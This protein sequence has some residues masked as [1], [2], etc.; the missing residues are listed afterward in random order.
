MHLA[1]DGQSP[2]LIN[3]NIGTNT[4]YFFEAY[5]N[6][7]NCASSRVPATAAIVQ[8]PGA[9]Q[10]TSAFR[11][12]PGRVSITATMGVPA[13]TQLM[14]F[15]SAAGSSPI[16]I[17]QQSPFTVTTPE[18]ST[19]AV[20]Y[21]VSSNGEGCES[22][23]TAVFV[24][25][26]PIPAPPISQDVVRCAG[27][28]V[29]FSATMANPSGNLIQLYTVP[30]GGVPIVSDNIVPYELTSTSINSNTT[31]YLET[32]NTV[33]NCSSVTRTAVVA[34][35][36]TTN[37][38]V[39]AQNDG[40]KCAGQ[41]LKLQTNTI[42]PGVTY[43]WTGPGGF[44]ATGNQ[45][46]RQLNSSL[47][48]GTYSVVAVANGCTSRVSSTVVEVRNTL[49]TPQLS[50]ANSSGQSRP[51]CEGEQLTLQVTNANDF[52]PIATYF[53]TGPLL[54]QATDIPRTLVPNTIS[55]MEGQYYVSVVANGCTSAISSPVN[56]QIR[57]NP[58]A[59]V[60]SSTAGSCT[61][62]DNIQLNAA[63][64]SGGQTYQWTGPNGFSQAGQNISLPANDNSSGTYFVRVIDVFGCVS[65]FAS[66]TVTVAAQP[67]APNL[68]TNAPL[69]ENANLTITVPEQFNTLYYIT[70]PNGYTALGPGPIFTR[71][72][73]SPL[74]AGAYSVTAI[75]GSCSS[76]VRSTQVGIV[77]K[78]VTP[79]LTSNSPV[80]SGQSLDFTIANFQPGLTYRVSGPNNYNATVTSANFSRMGV[81]LSDAGSYTIYAIQSG[82]SSQ[83]GS[84]NATV[85][86]TPS[87][88]VIANNGPL[89]VGETLSLSVVF[90]PG[91]AM[92]SWLGPNSYTAMGASAT[93]N[94]TSTQ[95][96]GI[97][98]LIASIGS[99]R[100]LPATTRA[101]V[102]IRPEQ[103]TVT[104]DGPKCTGSLI[105]LTAS[106]SGSNIVYQWTGPGG[107]SASGSVVTRSL[108]S[109]NE[110]GVYSV[111]AIAGNCTSSIGVTNVNAS[112]AISMPTVFNNGPKC[113]G[114]TANFTATGSSGA[115]YTWFGP[116]GFLGIGPVITRSNLTLSDNGVY[117]VTASFNGC[118]SQTATTTLQVNNAPLQ[119]QIQANQAPCVGNVLQ[120]T[121]VGDRG[122]TYIW[123]GPNNF[124]ATGATVTR[125]LNS[126]FDAGNYSVV[127]IIAGCTSSTA[128]RPISVGS[129][130]NP[131]PPSIQHNG[132]VCVGDII[133]LTAA[134]GSPTATYRWTGPNGFVA[135]G[136]VVSR[137][138]GSVL[139]GGEYTLEVNDGPCNSGRAL[140]TVLVNTA[141][142]P[143]QVSGTRTVC[144]GE[145]INLAA[146]N[147]SG[148]NY[149]WTGPAGFSSTQQQVSIFNASVFNSGIYSVVARNGNC[150][151]QPGTITIQVAE[152]PV[153]NSVTSNSPLCAGQTLLL[154]APSISGASYF[155]SGPN[156]YSANLQ[157]PSRANIA[158]NQAGNYAV[159]AVIGRCTS[160]VAQVSVV[161]NNTPPP[162]S[163][164][165]NGTVCSGQNIQLFAA[166]INNAN[167]QWTGPAGFTSFLQN[168]VI[169]NAAPFMSGI[170]SLMAVVGNCSSGVSIVN[171]RVNELPTAS[172]T[173]NSASICL[174]NTAGYSIEFT[175]TGPWTLTMVE[176][177]QTL[178]PTLIGSAGSGNLFTYQNTIT[179]TTNTTI[180]LSNVVDGNGCR[181]TAS[182]TYT[183]AVSR[184]DGGSTCP[185][186]VEIRAEAITGTSA[187][188]RWN[189]VPVPATCYI[190]A[191]GPTSVDPNTWTQQ[192]V[193]HPSDRLPITGLIPGLTYGVSVRTNCSAC[194]PTSGL[195]STPSASFSFFS[196]R[197]RM[198]STGASL[199]QGEDGFDVELYPNPARD[200]VQLMISGLTMNN[201]EKIVPTI[202]LIDM[203]G[204]ILRHYSISESTTELSLEGLTSGFYFVK[205]KAHDN[206]RTI[207]LLKQ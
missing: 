171:V 48:G 179:P 128:V 102:S 109:A 200:A 79:T 151:S 117:S 140:S 13:G 59:P 81:G 35:I 159:F 98:S 43:V 45:V 8:R 103:P 166:P 96:G 135:N 199:H 68:Q 198:S 4:T 1:S 28:I 176:N 191:Y 21:L 53:W 188:L 183:V 165:S 27:G 73:V 67:Q 24:Q 63:T 145:T 31:F 76:S 26:N 206:V 194:S 125:S 160:R 83:L 99:C 16:S 177:G 180:S 17:G 64:V 114:E 36:L 108:Q 110:A 190:V 112:P 29:T 94:L 164:S 127:A 25:L 119:P 130:A 207:K 38:S 77:S 93:R 197:T 32:V 126:I 168:P 100:S 161:V 50:F 69:C 111:I 162:P 41:T 186:P 139:D 60:P 52:P 182:G 121:A 137:P 91:G 167:Y 22:N 146:S 97:Y 19:N 51:L 65:P 154:T 23:R 62:N 5:N 120:L 181:G 141:P 44:S 2:Y 104:N 55:L 129:T 101:V 113:V 142:A 169:N 163:I 86:T 150:S 12:G 201:N 54:N 30:T 115:T 148:A 189:A 85:V 80:C 172:F 70:G 204:R 149:S 92:Y 3:A 90:G 138:T 34:S 18:L 184:C 175:G 78:S 202:E 56:V 37:I 152:P 87:T 40:P 136:A 84:M 133:F 153:L 122:A 196:G 66:V 6:Q 47:D 20:Y 203:H 49:P 116:S 185:P 7:N 74:D 39:F 147:V 195:I 170:Y 10:A 82:C 131:V 58:P 174:G 158:V 144:V 95:D 33:S 71:P 187:T 155:W 105:T 57:K 46:T 107:F 156:G 132:P 14:L 75:V 61:G 118:T 15:E 178:P 42:A 11:C 193:P 173:N 88:P 157:N 123:S 72:N 134:G 9:P 143:P 89:C 124:T 106:G 205:V 192:L